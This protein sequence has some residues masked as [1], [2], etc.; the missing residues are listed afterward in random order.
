MIVSNTA[1]DRRMTVYVLLA[2]F[3]T[4]GLYSYW[5]LPREDNPEV[6][7]PILLVTTTYQGVAPSDIESLVTIPIERKLTGLSGVKKIESSSAEGM[8]FIRIE[9]QADEDID[10][11][12]QRV[13]DKVD[14]A[15]QDIPVDADDPVIDEVNVS[16][17]PLMFLSLVGETSMALLTNC[18]EDLEDE[19]ESIKGVLDVKVVG[20]VEREIQIVVDPVRAAELGV[21]MADLVTL[22]RVENVNTPA[23]SMELGDAKFLV[24]VPGEFTTADEIKDLVVKP[25]PDG[26]VYIRD[27]AE[28]TDGFKDIETISRLDGRPAVTLTVSKRGGENIIRIADEVR[29]VMERFRPR[30]MPDM[31]MAI[32]MDQSQDIRDMVAEL[33]NSILSGL[34][35]VLGIIFIFIG[36]INATM[37][38]LA[39]PISMLITF[40]YL[41]LSG[42][43]LNMVVLFSLILALGMLVDNGIVVVENIYRHVQQGMPVTQAAKTGAG[44]V[45]WP[46]IASTLTTVAA[47]LPMFFWPGIWGSFMFY[48][49]QTVCA[50][51]LASLF[52]GLVVNPALAAVTMRYHRKEVER[53]ARKHHWT[54]RLYSVVLR[55]ALRWRAVT[56]TLFAT[57]LV[58]IAGSYL[59]RAKVEF[60][61]ETEPRR[62]YVNVDCPEGTRL[63]ITDGIVRQIEDIVRQHQEGVEFIIANAGSRGVTIFGEGGAGNS[64]LGRV[65]VDFLKLGTCPIKPTELVERI[66]EDLKPI[67]GAEVRLKLE[68]H[69]PS[70]APPVNVEISGDNFDILT[71]LAEKVRDRIKDVPNLVDLRDDCEQG[72]PEIRVHV[73]R[74]QALLT[75]L[76]TQFIGETVKAAINGRKAGDYREGDEE[77]DVTVRFPKPFRE[78]LTNL[79]SLTLVNLS[80]TAVPFS[81]VARLEQGAGLGSITRV[82]RKRTATVSAEV[83]GRPGPEVLKD[84]QKALAGF[85]MPPGYSINYTGQNEEQEEAQSFLGRAFII[86]LFLIALVIIAQFNSI[87]QTLII[88]SS[89]ILSLTGVF[90][91]LL[92]FNMSFSIIMTGIGCIS[93]A[94]VVVNN[95]IVLIDFINVRRREGAPTEDAIIE[96]GIT[97]FRPVMLTAITT[98]LGLMPMAIGINFDFLKW[99][100][101]VGGE[102]SQW[103]GAMAIS[104][105]SGLSFATLLTLIVVPTLYSLS[106]SFTNFF[107]PSAP[108][109]R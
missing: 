29:G 62:A 40:T 76:N 54:L 59:P 13:R 49:P 84:V 1:I 36:V 37:I 7:I 75:G 90:L 93:L 67:T 30:L 103:W 33:E 5:A 45:A 80:G 11:A 109:Q 69:G 51:L 22:A 24:R 64:H 104:V 100:W 21:S 56:V 2:L 102:S 87:L 95:A 85:P 105:I 12:R 92:I 97:R 71:S 86:A 38:S 73:D 4:T 99:E 48:L 88:M 8:S 79:E 72:K 57:L 9:F 91:G 39:I 32:T 78:N 108:E 58:V 83:D 89:V 44:E 19:L 107:L 35:L 18:A 50:A 61:P 25:G 98:V 34:I 15:M 42:T 74:Q 106:V 23:G 94:G 60:I 63:E 20:G 31:D 70:D 3:V 66:R 52:V 6:I 101:I 43:T 47:F 77:Y 55:R 81:A 26:A 68:Q 96:A 14:E 53:E 46:I 41:Y 27:I 82:D 17:L 28:V 10:Q 16:E 65:T